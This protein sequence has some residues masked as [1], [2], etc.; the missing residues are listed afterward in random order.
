MSIPP[1]ITDVCIFKGP[2]RAVNCS[3]IWNASSLE[4]YIRH[5]PNADA[6]EAN[7]VGVRTRANTPYGSTESL[8]NIGR[9]KAIVF[10]DPVFA[11]PTQSLPENP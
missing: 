3:D 11:F 7:L 9:A 5:V 1:T 2:P 10:P 8:C 4:F 6:N